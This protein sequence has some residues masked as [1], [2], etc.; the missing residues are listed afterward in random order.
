[1][2][3]ARQASTCSVS[4]ALIAE[5]QPQAP[6]RVGARARQRAAVTATFISHGL[7]FASWTAHIPHVKLALGLSDSTLGLVL[8][9]TPVGAVGAMLIVGRLLPR[10]GSRVLTRICLLG[11]CAAGPFV[12]L[13]SSP[14]LLVVALFVWGAFQG[15]LDV[16]MNTQ[17]VAIEGSQRR[18]LMPSFHGAWSVGAFAGAGVGA[19][20]VAAHVSLAPQLLVLALPVLAAA[21]IFNHSLIAREDERDIHEGPAEAARGRGPLPRATV[22]L[23]AT[24]FAA[25][26]CEGAT[27][28]WSAV[29]LRGPVHAGPATAGLGYAAFALVMAA[30]RLSGGQL[31]VRLP[32]NRLL[33]T[34]AALGTA[35]MAIALAADTQLTALIGFALLGAGLALVVPTVFRAA[36]NLPG[37]AP[38]VGIATVSAYGWAGFV[39]GPPLIGTLAGISGLRAALAVIPALTLIITLVTARVG[40]IHSS[41]HG[42]ATVTA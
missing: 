19:I 42:Y 27:A 26:L 37:L 35:A 33:P 13:A 10:L 17:A 16:A 25:M 14:L 15:S 22:I 6:R 30:V 24:V 28:D 3:C 20:A 18:H 32:A 12:G 21:A 38:G 34:L 39:C 5:G 40:V 2:L 9:A 11:Y 8:L 41:G 1:M 36:G 23:G 7:L 29:Y 4:R 31:L